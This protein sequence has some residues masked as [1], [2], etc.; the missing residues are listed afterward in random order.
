L[1]LHDEF[2]SLPLSTDLA[3]AIWY[4][5]NGFPVMEVTAGL[6]RDAAPVLAGDPESIASFLI[7]GRPPAAGE[8]FRN[9]ALA[10]S[11][12]RIAESGRRGFY[13][14]PTAE[15]IVETVRAHGGA[16]DPQDLSEFTPE[17]VDPLVVSYRGWK[18]AELPPNGQ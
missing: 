11:L 7:D 13:Q 8:T 4:A 9:P 2:G 14:G 10:R 16:M 15:A 6:W 3:P 12:R 17:W 1:A 5:E 18:V